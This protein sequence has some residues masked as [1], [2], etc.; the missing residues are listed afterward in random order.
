MFLL[1]FFILPCIL[2]VLN[3]NKK[4]DVFRSNDSSNFKAIPSIPLLQDSAPVRGVNMLTNSFDL[5]KMYINYIK[6]NYKNLNHVTFFVSSDTFHFIKDKCF[7]EKIN[8]TQDSKGI[9]FKNNILVNSATVSLA[10]SGL[11]YIS[12]KPSLYTNCVVKIIYADTNIDYKRIVFF[13]KSISQD[14]FE[15]FWVL[16]LGSDITLEQFMQT[17]RN[18]K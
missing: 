17:Y 1:A 14:F 4:M 16:F 8:F 12:E 18:L 6:V 2:A 5:L 10:D 11:D 3:H 9:M 7:L 15:T 13:N